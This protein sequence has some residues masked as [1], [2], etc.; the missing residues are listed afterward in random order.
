ML[1]PKDIQL[2]EANND[3]GNA[4]NLKPQTKISRQFMM[5]SYIT[6]QIIGILLFSSSAFSQNIS[7]KTMLSLQRNSLLKTQDYLE[8]N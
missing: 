7:L 1:P 6:I 4:Q 8:T 3:K 5:K 2:E